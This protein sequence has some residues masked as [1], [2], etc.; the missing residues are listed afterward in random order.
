M[1]SDEVR[2]AK[3]SSPTP[4]SGRWE[5]CDDLEYQKAAS[6]I[7]GIFKALSRVRCIATMKLMIEKIQDLSRTAPEGPDSK[8]DIPSPEEFDHSLERFGRSA[9]QSIKNGPQGDAERRERVEKAKAK[10]IAIAEIAGTLGE[11]VGKVLGRTARPLLSLAADAV[12]EGSRAFKAAASAAI[13]GAAESLE[14][15]GGAA[16]TVL[17]QAAYGTGRAITGFRKGL[18]DGR[19]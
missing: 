18:R 6:Q 4:V 3:T 10:I 5:R 8:E 14:K 16:M 19:Q 2:N 12:E 13:T 9:A 7:T 17:P 11:S 1:T 15:G